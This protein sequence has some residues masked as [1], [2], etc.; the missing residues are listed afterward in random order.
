MSNI[1]T[2]TVRCF[3]IEST[4][5][6]VRSAEDYGDVNYLFGN[7]RSKTSMFDARRFGEQ[8]CDALEDEDFNPDIDF[9]LL[10]GNVV[11]LA[12]A[13]A[14][15]VTE[16]GPFQALAFDSQQRKY[17]PIHLGNGGSL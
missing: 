1:E 8:V 6:D 10:A 16:W 3:C 7:H 13:V 17:V 5:H 15:I 9:F 11:A 14:A 4:S 2:S 12:V